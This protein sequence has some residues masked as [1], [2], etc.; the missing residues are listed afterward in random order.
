MNNWPDVD[1]TLDELVDYQRQR[2]FVLG[3]QF[4]PNLTPDDL[5]QPNDFPELEENPV[6]RYEEGVLAGV[7]AAQIALRSIQEH[8][9]DRIEEETDETIL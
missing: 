8:G 6:F 9:A 3:R 5:L 4:V 1:K 2:L 7:L